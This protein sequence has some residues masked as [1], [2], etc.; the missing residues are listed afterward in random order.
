MWKRITS[1][2]GKELQLNV[3]LNGKNHEVRVRP[4][5]KDLKGKGKN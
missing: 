5:R 3:E 2:C 1:K 4:I